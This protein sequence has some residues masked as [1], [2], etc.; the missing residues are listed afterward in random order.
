VLVKMSV[1]FMCAGSLLIGVSP[2]LNIIL[3]GMSLS[4]LP[5]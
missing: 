3:I 2:S 5:P 4:S 1:I